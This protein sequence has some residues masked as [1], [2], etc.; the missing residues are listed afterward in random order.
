M[1]VGRYD[2]ATLVVGDV[3]YSIL[4]PCLFVVVDVN[5]KH[6]VAV[7]VGVEAFFLTVFEH[8]VFVLVVVVVDDVCLG[9]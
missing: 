1:V 9:S 6:A 8:V 3:V 4:L 7:D 2:G 5:H